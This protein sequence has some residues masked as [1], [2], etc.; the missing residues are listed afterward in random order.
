MQELSKPALDDLIVRIV[1]GYYRVWQDARRFDPRAKEPCLSLG[2]IVA[3]LLE[4]RLELDGDL[5]RDASPGL[6]RH[7]IRRAYKLVQQS[8]GRLLRA[9]RVGRSLGGGMRGRE[10]HCYE[11][12]GME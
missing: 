8:L 9:K 4:N 3:D 6:R 10:V 5:L 2:T 11:P 12:A 7:V 1:E